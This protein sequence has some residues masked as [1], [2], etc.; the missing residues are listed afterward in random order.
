MSDCVLFWTIRYCIQI[1]GM[2]ADEFTYPR[3]IKKV[4]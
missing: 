3:D 2:F 4:K 1:V